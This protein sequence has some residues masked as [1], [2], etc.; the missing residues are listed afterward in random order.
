MKWRFLLPLVLI[1][2]GCFCLF[3]RSASEEL[4]ELSARA[5]GGDGEALYILATIYD[6]GYDNGVDSIPVDSIESTRLYRLSAEAGFLPAMNYLGYRLLRGEGGAERDTAEGLKWLAK[7]ASQGDAKAASNLGYLLTE[8]EL[9]EQDLQAGIAWLSKAAEAGLPVAQSLLGEKYQKGIG[10]EK[11]S[12]MAETL[13]REAFERGLIDAGYKLYDLKKDSY[14]A[15]SPR[16]KVIEGKYFYQ[17]NAPSEGVK[18][19]YMAADEGDA[20]A[21]ALLGDAYSRA[22]GVPYDYDL[23][24]RYYVEAARR[25]NPSAQFVVGELLEIFPDALNKFNGDENFAPLSPDPSWWFEQAASQG[26][27]DA[28]TASDRLL[29]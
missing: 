25:G 3:A 5:E 15:L 21:L 13:Y 19:F 28:E 26:I 24:L 9:V 18:L 20:E 10:V 7:A 27:T 23:S 16:E 14:E 1:A 22:I 4:D 11:D 29:F 12:V 17:R 6:N 8:G 2:A